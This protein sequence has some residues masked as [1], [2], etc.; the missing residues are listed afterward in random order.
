MLVVSKYVNKMAYQRFTYKNIFL[1]WR[2]M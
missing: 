1:L 2:N